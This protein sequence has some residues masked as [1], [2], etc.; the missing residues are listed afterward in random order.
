MT[1]ERTSG[2]QPKPQHGPGSDRSGRGATDSVLHLFEQWARETPQ[3]PAVHAGPD[4]LSYGQLDAR[5]D[6]WAH[7]LLADGLPPGGVVAI[8]TARPAELVIALLAVLKAGGAYSLLDVAT[9]RTGQRQLSALTPHVLLTDAAQH[10]RL[11]GGGSLRVIRLDTEAAAITDRPTEPPERPAP[12]AV[13]AV[14]FTGAS[15]P[16]AV[17]VDHAR[18]L[19]AHDAWAEV[20]RPTPEDRHLITSGQDVTAFAAGWTRALCSGGS[21][22]LPE[23]LP[24]TPEG[25]RRAVGAERV[26]VLHTDPAGA[27]R[28]LTGGAGGAGGASRPGRTGPELA[29]RSLRLVTVTGDRLFLDEQ[30]ALQ[31]RLRTGTRLLNVYGLTETA[32]VGTWFELSHLP[33]PLDDLEQHCLIGAPFPGCHVDLREGQL[34][35]TPPDG[36]DA[37]PTGDLGE[38]RPDGLLEFAGR[39]RDRITVDGGVLDPHSVEAAVRGHRDIGAAIVAEVPDG[40]G[41][42]RSGSRRGTRRLVAYLAPP[43]DAASWPPSADLPGIEQLRDHLAGKVLRDQTPH[44]VV[45]LRALPRNRAGQEDRDALPQPVLLA[46]PDRQEAARG[47]GKYTAARD[48]TYRTSCGYGCGALLLAV[49]G[50]FFLVLSKALWPGST[51][52]TGVPDPWSYLF[53]VLYLFEGAAFAGGLLFLVFGRPPMLRQGRGRGLTTAAHLAVVYLLVAWWPQDNAYRLAAKQDWPLQAA[54]VYTFNIPLMIAAALVV[55]YVTRKPA[56][57]FDFDD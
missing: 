45:R 33:G 52:L 30:A 46:P 38:L 29:A 48:G 24:W 19:A 27:T 56:S 32:G 36:G 18:L 47:A 6:R 1:P 26:D 31:G 57:P 35:L 15:V 3:A 20:T 13:A 4:L 44:A 42:G 39:I 21:L 28:L 55:R 54:L 41:T 11:D 10:A 17:P 49:A 25:I 14:L 7:H 40:G 51:D 50:L 34:H 37:L 8:G 43:A 23:C 5:A 2:S 22:V 12:G 53:F 9:P 16:R